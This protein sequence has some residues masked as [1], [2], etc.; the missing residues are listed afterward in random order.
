MGA[1]SSKGKV[2]EKL[3]NGIQKALNDKWVPIFMKLNGDKVNKKSYDHGSKVI[4]KQITAN[5][6]T[7]LLL[8]KI[9]VLL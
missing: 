9:F 2:D 8:I 5:P 7:F 3:S 6:T 4:T 1:A